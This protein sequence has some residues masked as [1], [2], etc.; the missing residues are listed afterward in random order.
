MGM[1][2]RDAAWETGLAY[3]V[4]MA[5]GQMKTK[6][7]QDISDSHNGFSANFEYEHPFWIDDALMVSWYTRSEYWNSKKTD[8][9]FGVTHEEATSTRPF[10]AA[11][12]SYS[13]H[14]GSNAFK[15]I[16]DKIT[17]IVSAEYLW[18]SDA[19]KDSP[20]TSRQDQWSAYAGV[21][22]QF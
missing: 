12:E 11:H 20:L 9:Y 5:G 13:F 18:M 14:L 3:E 21:F 10:Y 6:L 7:M 15:R 19:V 4:N 8:Y 2:D 16:N 1:D 22:Y 17:A